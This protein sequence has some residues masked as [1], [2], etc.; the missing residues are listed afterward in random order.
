MLNEFDKVIE[1]QNQTIQ[2]QKAHIDVLS[3]HLTVKENLYNKVLKERND[4]DMALYEISI[5]Y[6]AHSPEVRGLAAQNAI[7]K[8]KIKSL[9]EENEELNKII[10]EIA[11]NGN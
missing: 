10:D 2:I 9:Q 1:S 4:L 5:N 3:E 6:S 11:L 7:L 8:M